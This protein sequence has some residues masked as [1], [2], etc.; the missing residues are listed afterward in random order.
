MFTIKEVC[1]L[2][3]SGSNETIQVLDRALMIL[4]IFRKGQ[5]QYG[6]TEIAKR[7]KMNPSTTFRILQTL[8]NNGWIHQ[9]NDG[10]YISGTKLSSQLEKSNFYLALRDVSQTIMDLG[11]AKYK[12]AMNLIIR[13]GT[14]C[15]ILQQS[16]TTNLVDYV[17][18]LYSELPFYASAG[19]K[20]LFC[21]LPKALLKQM[22][23][24]TE[25]V[26]FTKH[27]ITNPVMFMKELEQVASDGYAF[28]N[29]ESAENGSCISVPVRDMENNIIAALSFSGFIGIRDTKDLLAYLPALQDASREITQQLFSCWGH[30][31]KPISD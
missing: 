29:H 25:L 20:I 1:Q 2:E 5:N 15:H 6:V 30:A 14:K 8:R 21:E 23:D 17:P 24:S 13:D 10:R 26:S 27:T 7:L 16:R 31:K 9:T 22:I 3:G 28:D 12:Q 18:P 4:E 19:G 11:T